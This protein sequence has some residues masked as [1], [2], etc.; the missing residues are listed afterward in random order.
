VRCDLLVTGGLVVD[1]AHGVES[2]QDLAVNGRRIEAVETELGRTGAKEIIDASNRLVLPGVVD[3]HVH[4]CP[5]FGGPQGYRMLVRAGVTTALD[6]AGD[7]QLIVDGLRQGG[8]GLT[9]G[10]LSPLIPGETVSGPSPGRAEIERFRDSAL[11]AGALGLKVL[12]GHYPL[13]PDA[14]AE[15]IRSAHQERVWCA[16]HAGTTATGSDI[17]GLEELIELA[18]AL[19]VHVAHVNS[20]CRG[21]KTDPLLEVRRALDAL[22][23]APRSRSESYLSTINGAHAGME[24]GVP[25]SNVVKTCLVMGGF[26]AT[27][28][29]MEDAIASGWARIHGIRDGE[30]LLLPPEEGLSEFQRAEA[31]V[32]VSFPVNPAASAIALAVARGARGFA[33]TAI[34][35]DG[36]AIPRNTTL[37]QGLALVRFGALSR[38]DFVT[39][40]CFNPARMMG[41]DAKG[42]L[43]VG[44]DADIV[45][46]DP[47]SFGVEWVIAGGG[48]IVREGHVVGSG[49]RVAT[50]D[51]SRRALEAQGVKTEI[52][53]A[54]WLN[55]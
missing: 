55:E 25:R 24:G 54:S 21:Q 22:A 32:G 13:T 36:G 8:A 49:G 46:V 3:T 19:P 14:T 35:T 12:G 5:P 37:E 17:E 2:V 28:K 42:Q 38:S 15:V 20:Y 9:I 31:Q 30:T 48:I 1:P 44:A 7:P 26:P 33:V 41:L 50:F 10:V 11:E 47:L 45:I 52:V 23:R 39:K 34:S 29:G 16:V 6:L 53:D 40:A 4:L 51:R 18:D 27:H 43:G